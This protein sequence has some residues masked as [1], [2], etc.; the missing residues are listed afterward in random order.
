MESNT[1]ECNFGRSKYIYVIQTRCGLYV[2]FVF[3]E[4]PVCISGAQEFAHGEVSYSFLSEQG[5]KKCVVA[6]CSVSL[7]QSLVL[8]T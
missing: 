6:N 5:V 2:C 1:C 4:E 7:G 3:V 8:Y